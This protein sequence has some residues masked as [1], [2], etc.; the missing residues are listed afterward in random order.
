MSLAVTCHLHIWLND[1]D[2]LRATAVTRE[3]NGYQNRVN[4]K[5]IL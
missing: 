1:R 5:A 4:G 3:W 2:L